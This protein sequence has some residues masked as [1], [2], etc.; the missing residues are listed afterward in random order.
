M[1]M[2]GLMGNQGL[3]IANLGEAVGWRRAY[4][5]L[6]NTD[7]VSPARL[8]EKKGSPG[9]RMEPGNLNLQSPIEAA[10]TPR[11][12]PFQSRPRNQDPGLVFASLPSPRLSDGWALGLCVPQGCVPHV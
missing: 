4:E 11:D 12:D 1:C 5:G 3:G 9:K 2:V 7:Y 6:V 10:P 8:T